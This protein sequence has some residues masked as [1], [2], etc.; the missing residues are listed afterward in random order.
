MK[1]VK[2]LFLGLL[3]IAVF[4]CKPDTK[5]ESVS[6]PKTEWLPRTDGFEKN[7]T[8]EQLIVLSRH[9]IRTPLVGEGSVLSRVTSTGYEWHNWTEKTSFLTSKGERLEARMGDFFRDWLLRK[10]FI[11]M[12]GQDPYAFRFYANAKQRCQET[13]RSFVR[14]LLPGVDAKVEMNV[15]YDTMDPVFNPQITKIS[16]SFT[17]KAQQEVQA[18]FGDLNAGI[19]KQYALV[20]DVISIK[21]SPAYPDTASF[22]QF[23]SSV[24]FSLNKEPAMSGG[25]KMACSVSDALVLQYYEEPDERKAAFGKDLTEED[26]VDVSAVKEWYQNVLFTA[27]SVS[28]N[29]AHPLLLTMLS[30][31]QNDRRVFSF[32]CGHDSNLGSVLAALE[33]EPCDLPGAIEKNTPI[34][35]K[36]IVETFLGKDGVR[37]A[38]LWLVYASASQLRAESS[39]SYDNPPMAAKVSLSGLKTNSYGLYTLADVEQRFSEAIEAYDAL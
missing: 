2:L 32:L 22:S 23:P 39:L 4:A 7:Y 6:L 5:T 9:N 12:Y 10:D 1:N 27:P 26:W 25:L 31:M 38:D 15:Q 24:N 17:E 8:L 35:G 16:S 21:N 29:V 11:A 20:E 14:A 13:A 28:V 3:A 19:A 36:L 33:A 18:M 37:Y 34:G 30:E